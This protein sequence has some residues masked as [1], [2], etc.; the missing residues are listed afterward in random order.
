MKVVQIKSTDIKDLS[1]VT[2]VMINN[3]LCYLY[4]TAG[5][6][7][8]KYVLTTNNGYSCLSETGVPIY[9]SSRTDKRQNC[10][11]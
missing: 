4:D 6:S 11:L 8:V 2:K 3:G 10:F 7:D 9:K 5:K 1:P